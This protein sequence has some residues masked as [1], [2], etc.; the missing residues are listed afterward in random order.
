MIKHCPVM[1]EALSEARKATVSATR[2]PQDRSFPE[3]PVSGRQEPVDAPEQAPAAHRWPQPPRARPDRLRP[4]T[5]SSLCRQRSPAARRARPQPRE[6][7]WFHPFQSLPDNAGQ[8]ARAVAHGARFH[9]AARAGAFMADHLHHAV[10]L[11]QGV[12]D[13]LD[14]ISKLREPYRKSVKTSRRKSL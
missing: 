1:Y 13:D 10:A 4:V 8:E 6:R 12:G 9:F 7:L 2:T 11:A 5:G 14:L 3:A